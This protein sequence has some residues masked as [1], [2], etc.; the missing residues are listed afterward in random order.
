MHI[1]ICTCIHT[2]VV[3]YKRVCVCVQT[4]TCMYSCI[5]VYTHVNMCKCVCMRTYSPCISTC[6]HTY[7]RTLVGVGHGGQGGDLGE[8]G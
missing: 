6:I 5:D 8:G 2:Y 7:I 1:H 3:T 4:C